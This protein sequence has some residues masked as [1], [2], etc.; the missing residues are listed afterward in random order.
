LSRQH[1]AAQTTNQAS[2]NKI[3]TALLIKAGLDICSQGFTDLVKK[4]ILFQFP[5][6]MYW[7]SSELPDCVKTQFLSF[8]V[9]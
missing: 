7:L 8:F 2:S 5:A 3:G 9:L 6:A 4:M 1:F